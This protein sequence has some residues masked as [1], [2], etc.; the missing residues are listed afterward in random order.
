M[1]HEGD[2]TL[3]GDPRDLQLLAETRVESNLYRSLRKS[4]APVFRPQGSDLGKCAS[5]LRR[6]TYTKSQC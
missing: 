1:L 6:F 3:K 2:Y 5:S 4:L